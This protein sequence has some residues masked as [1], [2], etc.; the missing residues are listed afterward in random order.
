VASVLVTLEGSYL[1]T[2]NIELQRLL[3]E[4]VGDL[5]FE[6]V[7]Y[8][9]HEPDGLQRAVG[10]ATDPA[11]AVSD[12]GAARLTV[13]DTRFAQLRF[14]LQASEIERYRALGRDAAEA[15][16]AACRQARSGEAEMD[17]AARISAEAVRRDILPLVNLVAADERIA[18][19][20]HPLPTHNRVGRTVLA[21]VT[22]RR[23]GL[24]ASLTRMVSFGEPDPDLALRH[25]AIRRVD[26]AVLLA[27][28]PGTSLGEVVRAGIERYEAEGFPGEWERHH[29]GGL[30]GYGGREIFG[31]PAEPY[32]LEANQVVAWNPSITRVKSEDTALVTADGIEIL[33][34]T[35]DWPTER[36]E[37][38]AGHVDRPAILVKGA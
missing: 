35:D 14:T 29:Q 15:V 31:T 17:L 11:G 7:P 2:T 22:G 10:S 28:T 1:L 9:W 19:Y 20:R 12:I 18:A 21:A 32:R 37:V 8:P 26:A 34:R 38:P 30:T 6:S 13:A 25:A 33:T 36:T 3:D 27:S 24:H 4:E 23:H 16:E 5:P